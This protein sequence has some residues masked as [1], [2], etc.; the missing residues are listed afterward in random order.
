MLR[1][2]III[3]L[4]SAAALAQASAATSPAVDSLL[5][6]LDRVI[7]QRPEIMERKERH[8]TRL[9]Q[10]AEAAGTDRERFDRL[11]D[12]FDAYCPYNADSAFAISLRREAVAH[13][14]ADTA[15]IYN[16]RMN[17]A[18]IMCATGLYKEA[19]DI[20]DSIPYAE[21][22][23]TSVPTTTTSSAQPTASWPTTPP[24]HP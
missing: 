4:A 3:L 23:P 22:P 14:T 7:A 5:A 12:L 16:A 6:E 2:I 17:R 13:R 1:L 18:G 11:G 10:A 24:T 20:M 19:L 21:L 15:L 8:L 9:R